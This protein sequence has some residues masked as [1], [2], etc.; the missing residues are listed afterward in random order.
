M[1]LFIDIVDQRSFSKVAICM[2]MEQ[3]TLSRRISML[4]KTLGVTLF[5]RETRPILPTPEGQMVYNYWKPLLSEFESSMIALEEFREK[6]ANRLSICSVDSLNILNDMPVIRSNM[7]NSFPNSEFTFVYASF[8]QWRGK[9][10]SGEVDLAFT[11]SFDADYLMDSFECVKV[12]TCPLLVCMLHKNPLSKKD[13]IT[14][15]DLRDQNFITISEEEAPHKAAFFRRL[16]QPHNFV[17]NFAKSVSNAHALISSLQDDNEVLLCERFLR[18]YDN[19]M[20]KSFPL[21]DTYSELCAIWNKNNPNT[22]I[23]PFVEEARKFYAE[24]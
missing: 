20:I 4:E 11:V 7:L 16:M 9:L 18:D 15:D 3:P 22:L 5:R 12:C 14:Y 2:H 23:A 13:R 21:P 6:D 10:L 8:S 1:K 19:P 17:P 24:H